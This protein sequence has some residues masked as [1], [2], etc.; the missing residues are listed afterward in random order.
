MCSRE[1]ISRYENCEHT[2]KKCH[3]YWEKYLSD[4]HEASEMP[5]KYHNNREEDKD[6]D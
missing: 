2:A 4:K 1:D 5:E 6:R 3:D